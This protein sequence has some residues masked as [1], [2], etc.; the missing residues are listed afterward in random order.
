MMNTERKLNNQNSL[1]DVSTKMSCFLESNFVIVIFHPRKN[2]HIQFPEED[3]TID[4]ATQLST[5]LDRG[6]LYDLYVQ[7]EPDATPVKFGYI[8]TLCQPHTS[9][10]GG[11]TIVLIFLN[12]DSIFLVEK[13]LDCSFSTLEWK[14]ISLIALNGKKRVKPSWISK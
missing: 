13:M 9:H 4:F 6:I 5:Q 7:D 12:I 14:M 3:P 1:F 10:F 11:K 2:I 8:E